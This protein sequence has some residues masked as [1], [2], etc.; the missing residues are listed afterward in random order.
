MI[1]NGR[2]EGTDGI[3]GCEDEGCAEGDCVLLGAVCEA[4]TG[5]VFFLRL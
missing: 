5:A 2:G 4:V 1:R 3:G